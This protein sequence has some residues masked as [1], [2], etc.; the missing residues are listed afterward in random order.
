MSAFAS[1]DETNDILRPAR[2]RTIVASFLV[3]LLLGF[4]PWPDLRVV[5]DFTALV[6]VFWCVRQPRRIGLGIGWVLGLVA[7]AG[8][9]VL[10]G[11][12]ALAYAVLAFLS[13]TFSR[14]I[15]WFKP[16]GQAAHVLALLAIGQSI[17][18][19]VRLSAGAEFPGVWLVVGP[20]LG[21]ALWPAAS[22]LL[23]LDQ[24]LPAKPQQVL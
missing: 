2:V 22:W 10:L 16:W 14:R 4:L 5:P 23:L 17:E 15:L 12:H 13:V 11:Q 7:D 20:L 6:L 3:A 1:P 21:A 9:G 24:R 8:N 18:L 19:L